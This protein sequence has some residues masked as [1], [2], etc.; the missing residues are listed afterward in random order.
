M[1]SK[2]RL[3]LLNEVTR[4]AAARVGFSMRGTIDA[5]V[6]GSVAFDVV[7]QIQEHIALTAAKDASLESALNI[8]AGVL[9]SL[10][11]TSERDENLAQRLVEM[12]SKDLSV[13]LAAV[14]VAIDAAVQAATV[15]NR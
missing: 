10:T 1:L 5:D 11:S 8:L 13:H 14:G 3:V 12:G 15:L 7:W 9:S 2:G 6:P 4:L